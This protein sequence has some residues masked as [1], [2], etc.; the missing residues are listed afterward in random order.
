MADIS[1]PFSKSHLISQ[2]DFGECTVYYMKPGSVEPQHYHDGIELVYILKG[3][4][5]THHQGKAYV[6]QAG[7]VHGII[8]DSA[9]EL[10]FTCMQI[11]PESNENTHYV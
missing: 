10:V 8:N 7:E 1:S 5:Q 3:N 6:Y 4:C 9:E 2:D 11:P